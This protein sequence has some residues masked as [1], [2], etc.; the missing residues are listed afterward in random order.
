MNI[1]MYLH[2]STHK[3]RLSTRSELKLSE[4]SQDLAK[5]ARR[6]LMYSEC[7]FSV[8]EGMRTIERQRELLAEGKSWTLKSYHLVGRA[9]DIYPWV[10]G[11]TSHAA[12]HYTM[13]A[14]AMFKASQITGVPVEWGGFW[15]RTVDKPH[16]Q[17]PPSYVE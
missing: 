14:M 10:D 2:N 4:I 12:E 6:A 1:K 11:K 15:T 17:L 5:L 16:W 7:D 9:V 13:V 8:V 3:W